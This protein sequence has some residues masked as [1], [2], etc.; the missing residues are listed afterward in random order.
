MSE[1]RQDILTGEWVIFAGNRKSRPYD[2]IKKNVPRST[3]NSDCQFCPGNESMTTEP[4]YQNGK[5]GEWTIRAFPNKFPAVSPSTT[6]KENDG[7]Y[8]VIGGHGV[9][10]V[11]VDTPEHLGTIHDFS[12]EHL[13]EVLKV[14]KKRYDAIYADK[15][16]KYVQVF[17][18][19]GPDSGA[20]IMHSH[21]QIIGVPVIPREQSNIIEHKKK[22]KEE[23]DSCIICAMVEYEKKKGIRIIDESENFIAYSPFASRLSYES[24]IAV[25]KHIGSFGEFD[26]DM[27][28]EFAQMLKN[29]L[30]GT[31]LVRKDICYNLCFED[32]PKGYDGHWFMRVIPRMGN[33]AGFEYG[34]NSYIN[35]IMPEDA[36]EF[37][38]KK[39]FQKD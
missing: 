26:D 35:P 34:T 18:N 32:T 33:P 39:I 11:I 1:L 24:D 19:C 2:F 3:D 21:W 20:S 37:M 14:V 10:E 6:D 28:F 5:D 9:H 30:V 25:K 31:K 12:V 16:I 15:D 13:F 8:T 29:I 23:K 36:A 4:V 7:F 27:L 38:R 22:Y 17:K